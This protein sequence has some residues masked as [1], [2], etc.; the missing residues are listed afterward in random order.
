MEFTFNSLHAWRNGSVLDF[1][2]SGML[3]NT[4]L[5]GR[6]KAPMLLVGLED[7]IFGSQDR[8][9]LTEWQPNTRVQGMV[10]Y[11]IDPLRVGGAL[12]YFGSYW[13][14]EGSSLGEKPCGASGFAPSALGGSRPAVLWQVRF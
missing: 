5:D 14:Q 6:I 12:R 11:S 9:I 4:E 7:T 13:V 8:S 10:D 2:V 3:V 1:G